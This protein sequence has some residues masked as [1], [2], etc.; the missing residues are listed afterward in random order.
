MVAGEWRWSSAGISHATEAAI[1]GN[2][3]GTRV[4]CYIDC[5]IITSKGNEQPSC[6]SWRTSLRLESWAWTN[7]VIAQFT[8]LSHVVSRNYLTLLVEMMQVSC[9]DGNK[10]FELVYKKKAVQ[11]SSLS[12]SLSSPAPPPKSPSSPLPSSPLPAPAAPATAATALFDAA[13][14]VK[15]VAATA[16]N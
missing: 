13:T 4:V 15:A 12:S 10:H 7:V 1:E 5:G 3:I 9:S 2:S 6:I 8:R 11:S 16:S 14:G